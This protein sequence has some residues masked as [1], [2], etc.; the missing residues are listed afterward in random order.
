MIFCNYSTVVISLIVATS[1]S[2]ELAYSY[3]TYFAK[4]NET[5]SEP[6][7]PHYVR[8]V[9]SS[10]QTDITK[11]ARK[12]IR[13]IRREYEERI[14]ELNARI[15]ILEKELI[16]Q[17]ISFSILSDSLSHNFIIFTHYSYFPFYRYSKIVKIL[18]DTP[19]K[20]ELQMIADSLSSISFKNIPIHVSQIDTNG[21]SIAIIDLKEL[22]VNGDYPRSWKG[23]Y[24]QGSLGGASTEQTL[25]QT[26]LQPEFRGRWIDGLRFFYN[27]KPISKNKWDHLKALK[28]TIYRERL[29]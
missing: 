25:I 3:N 1:Y 23:H 11:S 18:S 21:K 5:Q 14:S 22:D 8:T 27:G 7:R 16:Q 15:W 9:E 2:T 13:E 20:Q 28:Q 29:K 24:F 12:R 10:Q 17:K 26:F 19:L 6:L 4:K